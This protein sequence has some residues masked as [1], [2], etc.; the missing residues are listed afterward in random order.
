MDS[1][2]NQN[3]KTIFIAFTNEEWEV[4]QWVVKAEGNP[5][6][7]AHSVKV[8]LQNR[9]AHKEAVEKDQIHDH[10]KSLSPSEKKEFLEDIRRRKAEL[11]KN[12]TK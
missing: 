8:W 12:D 5:E 1:T 11:N 2:L 4:L 6:A 9:K 10:F 3:D 7:L